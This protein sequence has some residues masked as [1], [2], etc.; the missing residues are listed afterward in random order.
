MKKGL[1]GLVAII[2]RN[3]RLIIEDIAN[4]INLFETL[5]GGESQKGKE[6][7]KLL[8]IIMETLFNKVSSNQGKSNNRFKE[9]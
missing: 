1:S 6:V 3:K 9:D 5:N 8:H 7:F 2:N 4:H